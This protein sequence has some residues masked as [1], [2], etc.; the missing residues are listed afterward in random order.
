LT[1]TLIGLCQEYVLAE[2]FLPFFFAQPEKLQASLDNEATKDT[3]IYMLQKGSTVLNCLECLQDGRPDAME[4]LETLLLGLAY[5]LFKAAER[6][7]AS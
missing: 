7:G 1:A 3:T 6:G 5:D 4:Y 2:Q